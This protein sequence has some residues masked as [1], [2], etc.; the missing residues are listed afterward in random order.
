MAA[1][2]VF[3]Q[4]NS[5]GGQ[6]VT[7]PYFLQ[8]GL[9]LVLHVFSG[10]FRSLLCV[11]QPNSTKSIDMPCTMHRNSPGSLITESLLKRNTVP[12]C[13]KYVASLLR[14]LLCTREKKAAVILKRMDFLD[15]CLKKII[16]KNFRSI[17]KPDH[18]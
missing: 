11:L 17:Y 8:H 7:R 12:L 2:F 16:M 10:V 3:F 4:A 18:S 5:I 15:G 14:T 9:F 6:G 13:S 1:L